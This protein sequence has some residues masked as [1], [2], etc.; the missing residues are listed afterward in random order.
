MSFLLD[1]KIYLFIIIVYPWLFI[2]QGFDMTDSGFSFTLYQ[3][4]FNHLIPHDPLRILTNFL[5]GIFDKYFNIWGYIGFKIAYILNIYIILY[6]VWLLLKNFAKK[7]VIIFSFFITLIFITKT[8]G[9]WI[10]YNSFSSLFYLT[11]ILFLFYGY[12]NHNLIYFFIAGIFAGINIFIRFPNLL[13]V[14]LILGVIYLSILDKKP[15][16][17]IVLIFIFGY[18]LSIIIFLIFLKQIGYFQEYINSIIFLFMKNPN[19]SYSTSS[20]LKLLIKDYSILVLST[21]L[22]LTFVIYFGKY[23]VK[24]KKN[25]QYAS[26][27]C[28]TILSIYILPIYRIWQYLYVGILYFVLMVIIFDKNEN[29][30]FKFLAILS[31]LYLALI[32]L[33]SDNGIYNAIYGMWLAFPLVIIYMSKKNSLDFKNVIVL[34]NKVLRYNK[35]LFITVTIIFS[36]YT[37][38]HYTY[39]DDENRL[40]LRYPLVHH[41]LSGVFTTKQRAEVVNEFF[42]ELS[43]KLKNDRELFVY[44]K[45]ATTYYI[46]TKPAPLSHV[47]AVVHMDSQKFKNEFLKY[48]NEKLP[49]IARAKYSVSTF[50][51]PYDYVK[52]SKAKNK[53]KNRKI[54]ENFMKN[55][56]Y[57]KVWENEY[58]EIWDCI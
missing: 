25:I 24:Y 42:N 3:N 43:K 10:N 36:L 37:K 40:S 4:I 16:L 15:Y 52:L 38:Y 29:D 26:I 18:I 41:K 54:V 28:F 44:E 32:P 6:I 33:G 46:M 45:I 12:K 20:L 1:K 35:I 7:E 14:L 21:S 13:D 2:W 30:K 58:F 19:D 53:E 48:A 39:R 5:G 55:K 27:V 49:I 31:L 8:G 57:K 11:E 22:F 51:W 17:K 34:D 23:I 50:D 9:N 47:W 56:K